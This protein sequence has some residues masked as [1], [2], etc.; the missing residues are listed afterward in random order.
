MPFGNRMGPRN[1]GPMTG[2]GAGY[3]AGYT[4]P[5]YMNPA[6]G[7]CLGGYGRGFRYWYRATGL[8]GWARL[9]A[10]C[11]PTPEE[12]AAFLEEQAAFL[13]ERLQA[14]ESQL[15]ALRQKPEPPEEG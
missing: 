15:K 2:R 12:Q 9:G 8:P 14:L 1:W 7:F 10:P 11:A 3:C 5:G 4:V 13:R 6:W